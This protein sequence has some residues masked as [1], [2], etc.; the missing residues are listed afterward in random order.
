MN[1][2]K[3]LLASGFLF[4]TLLLVSV[5][6][7]VEVFTRAQGEVAPYISPAHADFSEDGII[8]S[9]YVS[10]GDR[11]N[12]GDILAELDNQELKINLDIFI[13]KR[14]KTENKLRILQSLLEEQKLSQNTDTEQLEEQVQRFLLLSNNYQESINN[15]KELVAMDQQK[16]QAMESLVKKN[17]AGSFQSIDSM[18]KLLRNRKDLLKV[19]KEFEERIVFEIERYEDLLGDVNNS[20]RLYE[21][22]IERSYVRAPVTGVVRQVYFSQIGKYINRG[23]SFAEVI[24]DSAKKFKIK[25]SVSAKDIGMIKADTD[26]RMRL[27]TY[28]HAIFGI[29]EGSV[30]SISVDR[31][32][33]NGVELYYRVDVVPTRHYLEVDSE[34]FPLKYGM[35]LYGTIERGR[36]SL[37]SYLLSPVIK[38][39]HEIG[40]I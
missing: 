8:K 28:D 5:F 15:L 34:R 38:H 33:E 12:Q 3:G 18:Q 39:F 6:I 4:I 10:E 31:L 19:K 23:D 37:L 27:D 21:H 36:I 2:K 20:I 13:S 17:A 24:E 32:H 26:V 11:V 16:S 1:A 25:L 35:T 40:H 7:P 22:Y 29:L 14:N 30:S 9:V